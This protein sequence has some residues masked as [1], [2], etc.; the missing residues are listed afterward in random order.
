MKTIRNVLNPKEQQNL[1]AP[2]MIAL[3]KVQ[4]FNAVCELKKELGVLLSLNKFDEA[5]TAK[6]SRALGQVDEMITKMKAKKLEH[7]N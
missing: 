7:Q 5:L 4:Y 2:D 1:I 3:R 6:I